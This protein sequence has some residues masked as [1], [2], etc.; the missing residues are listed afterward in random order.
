MLSTDPHEIR[1][2]FLKILHEENEDKRVK[3]TIELFH[4]MKELNRIIDA[5]NDIP[6]VEACR[7]GDIKMIR[8][9]LAHKAVL[10]MDEAIDALNEG[11][12]AA[13]KA[14]HKEIAKSISKVISLTNNIQSNVKQFDPLVPISMEFSESLHLACYILDKSKR[15]PEND[16][17]YCS[18]SV[19]YLPASLMFSHKSLL[20]AYI[21]LPRKTRRR[22]NPTIIGCGSYKEIYPALKVNLKTGKVSQIVQIVPKDHGLSFDRDGLAKMTHPNIHGRGFPR[23]FL[24]AKYLS[25]K[26]RALREIALQ[27]IWKGGDLAKYTIEKLKKQNEPVLPLEKQ[28]RIAYGIAR[29]LNKLHKTHLVHGDL[30][31]QNCLYDGVSNSCL[32]DFDHIVEENHMGP[33]WN[34]C[35]YYGT[36]PYTSPE[37]IKRGYIENGTGQPGDI[38][39]LGLVLYQLA[40][41]KPSWFEDILEDFKNNEIKIRDLRFR[42]ESKKS[43]LQDFSRSVKKLLKQS[44]VRLEI[45]KKQESLEMEFYH[46][47]DI[48]SPTVEQQFH[49]LIYQMLL[50]VP[51]DRPSIHQIKR[52][53][54]KLSRF[55]RN[56]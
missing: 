27:E 7:L 40:I 54:R 6:V 22:Q 14:T 53:L 56:R 43:N 23:L 10:N 12:E 26:K 2:S 16:E 49:L 28:L 39:A 19:H 30:K 29:G 17:F 45:L 33:V 24:Q 1:N 31:L 34:Q 51:E 25:L 11:K 3:K 37:Q 50:P 41:G 38:Y 18:K 36:V 48:I 32:T 47:K 52:A 42:Y 44:P 21:L 35:V 20:R 13:I 9:Y 15:L 8:L 55:Q 5:H 46:L 4:S